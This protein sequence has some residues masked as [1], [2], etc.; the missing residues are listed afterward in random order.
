[1]RVRILAVA[2]VL[3]IALLLI[4]GAGGA[5]G[6]A[7]VGADP[8]TVV[9]QVGLLNYAG[10]NCPGIGWNCT[11]ATNVVQVASAGGQNRFECAPADALLTDEDTNICVIDQS[12]DSNKARCKL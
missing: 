9:K 3:A 12:G 4:S 8:A 6:T 5:V 1:M 2:G 7:A 11:T 10:P